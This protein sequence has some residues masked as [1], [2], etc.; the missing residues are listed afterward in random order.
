MNHYPC[1]HR[2]ILSSVSYWE[3]IHHQCW[4]RPTYTQFLGSATICAILP[5]HYICSILSVFLGVLY[6]SI[7]LFLID[8]LCEI[9]IILNE[10]LGHSD[11]LDPKLVMAS[12]WLQPSNSE[13]CNCMTTISVLHL[14]E[15]AQ[16]QWV[17]GRGCQQSAC[18]GEKRGPP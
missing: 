15:M 17:C 4:V 5:C 8:C 2:D 14:E 11:V 6:P 1:S 7:W 12:T 9:K 18:A 10:V 13:N 3:K 16:N